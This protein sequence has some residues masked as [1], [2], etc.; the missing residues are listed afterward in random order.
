MSISVITASNN[1]FTMKMLHEESSS[2]FLPVFAS[3]NKTS[4]NPRCLSNCLE[5]LR[6]KAQLFYN[7]KYKLRQ[8]QKKKK[9]TADRGGNRVLKG[10]GG[11]PGRGFG[12]PQPRG[13]FRP[14]LKKPYDNFGKIAFALFYAEDDKLRDV[15][16][17]KN[18]QKKKRNANFLSLQSFFYHV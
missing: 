16:E 6:R 7:I 1:T 10:R 8:A 3:R 13:W 18:P 4:E 9:G 15:S 14:W 2:T 12:A 17:Q 11:W 5:N